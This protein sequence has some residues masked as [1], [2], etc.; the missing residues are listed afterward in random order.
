MIVVGEKRAR[1][2]EYALSYFYI[3]MFSIIIECQ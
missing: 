3:E 2:H 1:I